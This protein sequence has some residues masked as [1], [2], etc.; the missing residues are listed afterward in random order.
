[1]R[2]GLSELEQTAKLVH[3]TIAPTPAIA[4]PLLAERCGCEV[5]VKHENHLPTGA[6]KLRGGLAYGRELAAREPGVHTLV[7]AT[8]GNHGQSVACAARAAGLGAR[9]VVP[10]GNSPGKNAAMR[11]WGATLVEHGADF[12]AALE[13]ARELAAAPGHHLV[14]SFDWR[15]VRGVA[16]WALE[17]FGQAAALDVL[18]VPIGL[19]SGICGAVAARDALGLG[20]RIVGVVAEQAPAYALSFAR[21]EV[22]PA[23]AD[24][25]ADGL[26]VRLPDPEAL[27]EI[28]RG[29]E[30]VVAVPEAEIRAAVRHYFTDTH[31]VAEGAAAA[32][33][34]AILREREATRGRRIGVVLTGGNIDADVFADALREG[35]A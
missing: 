9:I 31:N 14:P 13:H 27:R 33:L 24:T 34:A 21:G 35:T 10:H 8:R 16:S 2:L 25:F 23:P 3:E 22:V 28:R 30:R 4:W 17:L 11:A 26:A 18:Y 6:F 5:V 20:T 1:V 15:L 12:S 29:V 32:A 19:G 7:A